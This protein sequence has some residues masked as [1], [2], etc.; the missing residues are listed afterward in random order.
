LKKVALGF[1]DFVFDPMRRQLRRHGVVLKVDSQLLDL[2]ECFLDSPGVLLSKRELLNRVWEGRAVADSALSVAVAKLRRVLGHASGSR[3][4]IENRYGRGYRFLPAVTVV[5]AA[6]S[7]LPEAAA[8]AAVSIPLVGRVDSV[9]QL[10]AAL[11]RAIDGVG[12]MCALLGEPGIGKTRLAEAL[13]RSAEQRGVRSAWGRFLPAEGTPPLWPIAQ[14]LRALNN[15]GIADEALQRIEHSTERES[16]PQVIG[17]AELAAGYLSNLMSSIHGVIDGITQAL[18][19]LSQRQPLLIVL[20][21][22]QWADAATLRLLR[23]LIG[24]LSR[25]PV[26]LLVCARSSDYGFDKRCNPELLGLLSQPKCERIELQRLSEADVAEFTTA[27]FGGDGAALASAVFARSEGCPFYMIELL[28]PWLGLAPPLPE[29]LRLSGLALDLV[30]E[31]LSALPEAARVV[32]SAA[33]VI[34]HDFDLGMLSRVTER[35]V[36]DLL[37]A[38]DSS[39]ANE[40]I[41]ASSHAPGAYAFDHE[42][43]REVLYAEL[44]ASERCRLHLRVGESL[45]RRR[46]AGVQTTSAQ[47]AQHFL[48]ALPQGQVSV[49]I[50]HA[51]NA[52]AAATRIAAHADAR[53]LL[54]RALDSLRFW[55]EPDPETL[56]GLLLELAMVERFLGDAAN[57]EHLRQGVA[58]ARKHRFGPLLTLAGQLLSPYPGLLTRSDACRVLEAA[59]EVL[60]ES[61]FKR[62]AIVE[63]HLAWVPPNC[64]SA[65]KVDAHM[66][67]AQALARESNDPEALATVRDA[68]LFF[69]A[70]PSSLAAAEVLAE[71][72][73]HE[74][75]AHPETRRS[76]RVISVVSFRIVSAMQRG[77]KLGL[78]CAL[79]ERLAVLE[80]LNNVELYWHYERMLLVLRMNRGDFANVGV[81]LEQLRQSAERRRLQS[82]PALWARDYGALLLWTGDIS[83][84]AE[85][86]RPS[87]A[88]RPTES[89]M[90]LTRKL[91][92]MVDFGFLEDARATLA[93]RPSEWLQDLPHD[94]D[95][96]AVTCQ[97]AFASA[98]VGSREHCE[99]LYELLEPYSD[100]YCADISFHSDGSVRHFQGL[101][102]V[103]LGRS[104]EAVTHFERAYERNARFELRACA[105]KSQFELATLL[106]DDPA[107]RDVPRGQELLA[108]VRQGAEQLGLLALLRTIDHGVS[109][110]SGHNSPAATPNADAQSATTPNP[111]S[112]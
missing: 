42:L 80:Q 101:L 88:I 75:A 91:R 10:E 93:Q 54:Q 24:E 27:A 40:T 87:L 56:T 53:V 9:R 104:A 83:E 33:A 4:Y 51:R 55:V 12:G 64:M 19:R 99:A 23:Y 45:L 72:I 66:A 108:Q 34:G 58:L 41:V 84:L 43:I 8:A 1:G 6:P 79:A 2:L 44:P 60:P 17:V 50:A 81:E 49:A 29:Q 65:R 48:S 32:L 37:E 13:V 78:S 7:S 109:A 110:R 39:L 86:V 97:L 73:Q 63:A 71:E 46:E 30:R 25:W 59:A 76:Q 31:R 67:E 3:E 52:A 95:Y 57:V 112:D 105:L 96:L 22:L 20:D 38:L 90:T 85:R 69:G 102:A 11:T 107:L 47:L 28:R 62:R 21:D 16:L 61:D 5:E 36:G 103:A 89:P 98:A 100:F 74:L 68:Q 111:K 106:L 15:E 77:D 70:G 14:V 82:W 35:S 26:L 92:S 18:L 94:R